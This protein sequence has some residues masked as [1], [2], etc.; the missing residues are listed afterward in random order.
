MSLYT[1]FSMD[2]D[3]EQRG[4]EL[5]YG[6][7]CTIRI[8]RAGGSNAAFKREAQRFQRKHGRALELETISEEVVTKEL[9]EI[10]AK[11]VVLG[12]TG[13]T[14]R[15]G[16]E[17][18]FSVPNCVRLFLDLPEFFIDIRNQATKLV[19]FREIEREDDSGN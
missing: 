7:G 8:A 3:A 13:V 4:I 6:N 12:W 19:L 9:V 10:F 17:M 18:D 2:P 11:T 5:D 15:A 14:D 1:H 16:I